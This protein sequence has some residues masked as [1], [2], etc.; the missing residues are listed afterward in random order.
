MDLHFYIQESM[1]HIDK[2]QAIG[3]RRIPDATKMHIAWSRWR[4]SKR[5]TRGGGH[6]RMA[7]YRRQAPATWLLPYSALSAFTGSTRLAR[8][9]GKKAARKATA[10]IT[11]GTPRKV[12]GS[13]PLTP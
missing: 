7:G 2:S 9:A 11:A 13:I 12:M 10:A 8:R 4:V 6:D 5:L 3:P 1:S